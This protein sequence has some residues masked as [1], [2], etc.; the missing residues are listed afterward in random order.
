MAYK[1]N[2]D[3]KLFFEKV[4]PK[5]LAQG[6]HED[7]D[8]IQ[9]FIEQM[10]FHSFGSTVTTDEVVDNVR[11]WFNQNEDY[12]LNVFEKNPKIL[13]ELINEFG[14]SQNFTKFILNM[15]I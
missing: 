13:F 6:K 10:Y 5:M 8:S 12:L 1:F 15:Q 7:Y 9:T 14:E 3:E 4:I 2:R 11:S